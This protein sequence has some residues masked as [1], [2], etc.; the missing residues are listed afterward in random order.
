MLLQTSRVMTIPDFVLSGGVRLDEVTIA[1]ETWG[2]LNDD[3]SNAILLCHGYTNHPHAA[4]DE[5]GWCRNLVGPGLA[6]D[7][8]RYFVICSNMLGSAYGTTGPSSANPSTGEPF[9]PCFPKYSTADMVEAQRRLLDASGIGQL[10]AVIGYSYGGHLTYLWGTTHPS[11]M[12]ALV[13]IAGTIR[14]PTTRDQVQAIRD[15]FAER[16]PGWNGGHYYGRERESGVFDEMVA[17]RI[18]RLRLYG[19]GAWLKDNVESESAR[20]ALLR[21]RAEGWAQEF[22]AN[23]LWVLYEAGIGS[24]ATPDVARIRAPLLNVLASSDSVVDVAVGQPTVD[25]LRD[26]GVDARFHRIETAYGHSG[27]ML[28]AAKWEGALRAFLEEHA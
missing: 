9:G 15:R 28:D 24:D 19:L 8:D 16:C 26:N 18:E 2:K 7:T 6:I 14:R 17:Q 10:A 21:E 25:L 27:P 5:N 1:Y 23:S 20:E 22:D 4:G 13:P 12:R 3:A 11:R